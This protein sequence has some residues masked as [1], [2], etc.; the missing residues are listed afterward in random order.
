[1]TPRSTWPDWNAL[2]RCTDCSCCPDP[3]R[4]PFLR[5]LCRACWLVYVLMFDDVE[6]GSEAA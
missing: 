1:M 4:P 2:G 6:E 5:S 3:T